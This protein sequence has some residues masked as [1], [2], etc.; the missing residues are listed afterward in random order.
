MPITIRGPTMRNR[1]QAPVHLKTT[2]QRMINPDA[3]TALM[4]NV[5]L[6]FI[7]RVGINKYNKSR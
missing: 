6:A 4:I 2:A 3:K 7:G 1:N 5:F